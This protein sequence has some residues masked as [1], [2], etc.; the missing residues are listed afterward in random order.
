MQEL[1]LLA[2]SQE[3]A[4]RQ[5]IQTVLSYSGTRIAGGK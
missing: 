4:A 2:N 5:A 1:R 3:T